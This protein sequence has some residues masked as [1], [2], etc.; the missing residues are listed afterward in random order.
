[1][2]SHLNNS[3][4]FPQM[5]WYWANDTVEATYKRDVSFEIDGKMARNVTI[6]KFELI[7][8]YY[9]KFTQLLINCVAFVP[10]CTESGTGN[11]FQWNTLREIEKTLHIRGVFFFFSLARVQKDDCI[12]FPILLLQLLTRP[13]FSFFKRI[14][15][16][17]WT[18]KSKTG[19]F[20][21]N[22]IDETVCS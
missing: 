9:N 22:L 18:L 19:S 17:V 8:G 2:K 6:E 4:K 7:S 16:E 1:M 20:I 11:W 21:M 10:L 5:I 13:Q 14:W 3:E 15:P 12:L